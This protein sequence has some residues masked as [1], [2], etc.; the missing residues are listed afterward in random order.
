MARGWPD[1]IIISPVHA[2]PAPAA[3]PPLQIPRIDSNDVVQADAESVADLFS[4]TCAPHSNEDGPLLTGGSWAEM[5]TACKVGGRRGRGV[6][7]VSAVHAQS[8][9]AQQYPNSTAPAQHTFAA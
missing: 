8:V 6:A 9:A 4:A 5:C 2:C 3:A 7:A 1:H